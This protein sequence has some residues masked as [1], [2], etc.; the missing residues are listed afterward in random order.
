MHV[1]LAIRL[2]SDLPHVSATLRMCAV[3]QSYEWAHPCALDD[4]LL[5]QR[6]LP[7]DRAAYN[8]VHIAQRI[9]DTDNLES[10]LV[11]NAN[12]PFSI[13]PQLRHAQLQA[14]VGSPVSKL[15]SKS[16][17]TRARKA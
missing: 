13:A 14:C 17:R 1:R 2:S 9:F 15:E 5:E 8:F 10:L 7:Y 6:T 11:P 4:V 3:A 16:A 12:L